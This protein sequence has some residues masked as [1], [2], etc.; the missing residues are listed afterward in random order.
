M[1]ELLLSAAADNKHLAERLVNG[2]VIP[3]SEVSIAPVYLSLE[4]D[5]WGIVPQIGDA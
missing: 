5:V 4:P 1:R 2:T 3:D